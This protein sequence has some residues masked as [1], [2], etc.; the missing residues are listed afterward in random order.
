MYGMLEDAVSNLIEKNS[1]YGIFLSGTK[2]IPDNR[3]PTCMMHWNEQAC[4]NEIWYNPDFIEE[5]DHEMRVGL[6]EHEILHALHGHRV[7]RQYIDADNKKWN[8]AADMAINPLIPALRDL[9][10]GVLPSDM[11]LPE[12]K[13]AEWYY[14]NIPEDKMEDMMDNMPDTI[15]IV[16][17]DPDKLEEIKDKMEQAQDADC[18]GP[19]IIVRGEAVDAEDAGDPQ[20]AGEGQGS[21][22]ESDDEDADSEGSGG[23][24]GEEEID[25]DW[26]EYGDGV[27]NPHDWED[28]KESHDRL[29][30]SK[31][32]DTMDKVEKQVSDPKA[33]RGRVPGN[34]KTYLDELDPSN[35]SIPWQRI[36]SRFF[37]RCGSVEL[38]AEM[39]FKDRRYDT[40]P[41]IRAQ[42][43]IRLLVGIDT[44]GSVQDWYIN[45]VFDEIKPLTRICEMEIIQC[46]NSIHRIDEWNGKPPE[47]EG[48]GGT[49]FKPVFEY[50]NSNHTQFAGLIYFTDGFAPYPNQE[51][52]FPVMWIYPP[53]HDK[54][55]WG[56]TIS[57]ER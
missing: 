7:R 54:C 44:S 29:K 30:K 40:R 51:P 42:R 31:I 5:C 28:S 43:K 45:R 26:G 16:I 20:E 37:R 1:H 52:K 19:T 49:S 22:E 57:I 46:D 6:V 50:F 11:D 36:V 21:G 3:I 33:E 2:R 32:K 23:S 10:S 12:G 34:A 39:K 47:I 9:E 56:K 41:A 35:Q 4:S 15:E 27:V 17:D 38:K 53:R 13:T 18:D 14:R 48:R 55:S 8:A 25:K 24:D